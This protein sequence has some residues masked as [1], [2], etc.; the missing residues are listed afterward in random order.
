MDSNTPDSNNAYPKVGPVVINEIMYHPDPNADAEYIEL[1]NIT[2]AD[3]N[4]FDI[5][6][7]PWKFT[8]GI[9]FTFPNDVNIPTHS[10]LLVV[11]DTSAFTAEYTSV[12]GDVQVF[13]WDSGRLAND[14]ENIEISMPGDVDA[15]GE[16]H[17]IR[18]DNV[19]FDDNMPWPT[20]PD[21]YD[22]ALIRIDPNDY[23]NDVI[24]WDANDP[25]PGQ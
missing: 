17:Y 2:S 4:L 6:G 10:Y 12:P 7:N 20:T 13:Q 25:S 5:E 23:G 14:G 21:G 1:Y 8:D 18:I 11:R 3:V 24:N 19:R 16:C 22:Q 9:E 15:A